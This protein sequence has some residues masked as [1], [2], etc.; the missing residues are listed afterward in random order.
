[1]EVFKNILFASKTS[2]KPFLIFLFLYLAFCLLTFKH[3]GV[4]WYEFPA[5][6]NAGQCMKYYL[7]QPNLTHTPQGDWNW[8]FKTHSC[9]NESLFR[10]LSL[11]KTIVPD[12]M[13]LVCLL[14]ALPIF[15]CFFE[16][17]RS[18][19]KDWR[20]ALAGLAVLVMT[21]RFLGDIPG[22]S[23]D[24]PFAVAYFACLTAMAQRR[25]WIKRPWAQ[26]V[27]LGL[28]FGLTMGIRILAFTLFPIYLL[29]RVYED[30]II[31]KRWIGKGF[32]RWIFPEFYGFCLVVLFSQV[33]LALI[34]PYLGEDYFHHIWQTVALSAKYAFDI[35]ILFMGK[36]IQPLYHFLWYYLPVWILITTPIF[37]LLFAFFSMARFRALW[38]NKVYFI[39]VLAFVF[40][41][42]LYFILK[43]VIYNSL[44]LFLFLVPILSLL[45]CLGIEDFFMHVKWSPVRIM[46]ALFIAVNFLA[47][48]TDMIRL[49]PYDYVYFN[50][51]IGGLKGAE[52][53]FELDYLG[54]SLREAT[55]WLRDN[56]TKDPN[57]V[58][59]IR[60]ACDQWQELTYFSPNMQ[61]D[62]TFTEK[63]ADYWMMINGF[64]G[65]TI[66][67]SGKVIHAVEREE[68]PLSYIIK[69]NKHDQD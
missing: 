64:S 41:L 62:P 7:G 13:H 26:N 42:S 23:T 21:P 2:R 50:E 58:Y 55:E 37:I 52:G 36:L 65:E 48:T 6:I 28:L 61:G 56:E 69:I 57:K 15:W 17:L 30:G 11:S 25:E 44:R 54:A 20:W 8:E 67:K 3:Y 45:A 4:T 46:A 9:Y 53:K 59:K 27:F 63:E 38:K 40:N 51:V 18:H 68:V 60:E 22:N 24:V 10:I 5:Y 47:V 16:A 31:E 12:R 19:F 14:M 35:K 32:W 1:M 34:W 39:M 43:P 33:L 29:Y 66:P 49:F